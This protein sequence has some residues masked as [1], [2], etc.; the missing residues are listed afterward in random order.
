MSHNWASLGCPAFGATN[1]AAYLGVLNDVEM[2]VDAGSNAGDNNT[3]GASVVT[4][5]VASLVQ[6]VLTHLND[7]IN[8]IQL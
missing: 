7:V 1:P 5:G 4:G 8:A 6:D 3:G 2:T